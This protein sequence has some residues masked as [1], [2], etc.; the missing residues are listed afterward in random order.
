MQQKIQQALDKA[1]YDGEPT[2]QNL[3]ECFLD[4]ADA[5]V[6]SNLDYD[7]AKEEIADGEITVSDM[8]RAI[9]KLRG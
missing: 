2:A 8:C 9:M 4:Y 7:D 6:W 3:T 1:G 5:G